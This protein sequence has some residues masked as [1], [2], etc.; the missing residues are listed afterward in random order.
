M[1]PDRD[2]WRAANLLIREHAAEAEIVSARR[3]MRCLNAATATVNWSGC[4]SDGRLSSYSPHP[5][6]SRISRWLTPRLCGPAGES[7]AL[8]TPPTLLATDNAGVKPH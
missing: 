6:E 2:I 1:I 4:A 8:T 7:I 5:W 3:L